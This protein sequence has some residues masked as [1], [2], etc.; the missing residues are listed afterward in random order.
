MSYSDADAMQPPLSDD[1]WLHWLS[2]PSS[3][4][5]A[6]Q[7]RQKAGR[8]ELPEHAKIPRLCGEHLAYLEAQQ[9]E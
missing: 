4:F 1:E 5:E 6:A 2:G 9:K 8:P 3:D 7:Q